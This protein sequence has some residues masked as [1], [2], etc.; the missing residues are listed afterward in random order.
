MENDKKET[1]KKIKSLKPDADD[2]RRKKKING[3]QR[4]QIVIPPRECSM[5]EAE[6]EREG[7]EN[8]SGFILEKLFGGEENRRKAFSKMLRTS[9]V[10]AEAALKNELEV[11]NARLDYFDQL[12]TK[13]LNYMYTEAPMTQ[14]TANYWAIKFERLFEEIKHSVTSLDKTLTRYLKYCGVELK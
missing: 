12:Y 5:L 9:P 14:E 6:M 3:S 4:W 7:W 11:L 8:R 10:N 1:I 13:Q 2:R